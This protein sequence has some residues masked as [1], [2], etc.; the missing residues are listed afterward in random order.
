MLDKSNFQIEVGPTEIVSWSTEIVFRSYF[1]AGK[2]KIKRF[3]STVHQRTHIKIVV[4]CAIWYHF[5]NFKK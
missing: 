1:C 2:R 5:Y 3:Q 4:L